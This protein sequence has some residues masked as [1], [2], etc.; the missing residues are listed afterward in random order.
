MTVKNW[1]LNVIDLLHTIKDENLRWQTDNQTQQI[2]L[3]QA[4]ILAEDQL[5]A[6]LKKKSIQL[7]HEITLL[8]TKNATEL[9]MFKIKCKQNIKDYKQ[10]LLALDKLKDSIQNS[11]THL[12][13]AVAFTIH[14]HA[15]YLLN[16]VWEAEDFEEKM[17]RE[18]LLIQ[19]M[20]T[21][22]EDAST[23]LQDDSLET[24]PEKTLRL[25]N[26]NLTD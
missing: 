12:P 4:Q 8:E 21:V 1:I 23:H 24:L 20:T 16:R 6:E 18:M 5:A 15:Q 14:H 3:K 17:R 26:L 13:E 11:Y 22:H 10:Y 9:A 25:I 7:A 2:Q 19:F